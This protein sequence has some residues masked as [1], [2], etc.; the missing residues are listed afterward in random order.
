MPRSRREHPMTR[1]SALFAVVGKSCYDMEFYRGVR[2][3]PVRGA[4]RYAASF[5]GLLAGAVFLAAFLIAPTLPGRVAE[6]LERG[7]PADATFEFRGDEF[8]SSL[9]PGTD[10]GGDDMPVVID[11]SA[12]R[13]APGEHVPREGFLVARDGLVLM[14]GGTVDTSV[15]YRDMPDRRMTGAE[16]TTAVRDEGMPFAVIASLLIA[17]GHLFA[18]VLQT[19]LTVLLAA[20]VAWGVGGLFRLRMTFARWYAVALHAVTLPIIVD[21]AALLLG[22]PLHDVHGFLLLMVMA[23]VGA[24]EYWTPAAP[25]TTPATDDPA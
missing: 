7:V 20:A 2:T 16:I 21:H 3:R 13:A 23:A 9:A 6:V 4:V 15:A 22:L 11:A 1:L 25:D 17:L 5:L 8:F 14:R 12:T 24:D 18:L 10:L 19:A